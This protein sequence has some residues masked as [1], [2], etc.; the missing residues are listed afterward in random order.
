MK[1]KNPPFILMIDVSLYFPYSLSSNVG[2]FFSLYF[3][4]MDNVEVVI[5]VSGS[6][7]VLNKPRYGENTHSVFEVFFPCRCAFKFRTNQRGRKGG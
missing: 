3:L 1:V 2:L 6:A 5:E 7:R 4:C